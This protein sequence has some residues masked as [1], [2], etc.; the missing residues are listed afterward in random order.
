MAT[1]D[2]ATGNITDLSEI[3]P[4]TSASNFSSLS[5]NVTGFPLNGRAYNGLQFDLNDPDI[6][7]VRRLEA[8]Q[9]Q[10]PAAIFQAAVQS[11]DGV[12]GS[13]D[14]DKF[15]DLASRVYV[16]DWTLLVFPRCY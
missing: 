3:G 10:L 2:I 13:F 5:A 11:P 9:L 14:P 1:A 6:F 8:L 16:C 15:V 7:V 12:I 4:F